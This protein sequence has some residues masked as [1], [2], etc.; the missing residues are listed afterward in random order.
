MNSGASAW[1]ED[2]DWFIIHQSRIQ[3]ETIVITTSAYLHGCEITVLGLRGLLLT[4]Y[5]CY[6]VVGFYLILFY[7]F[8]RKKEYRVKPVERAAVDRA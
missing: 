7:L 8:M 3:Y 2:W 5:W 6:F 4:Y 1:N